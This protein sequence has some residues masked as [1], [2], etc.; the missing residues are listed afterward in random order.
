MKMMPWRS[1]L[2]T[3]PA[4]MAFYLSAACSSGSVPEADGGEALALQTSD[5]ER[6]SAPATPTTPAPPTPTATPAAPATPPPRSLGTPPPAIPARAILIMDEASQ[7]SLYELN[8]DM[9]LAPASLTKIATAM[10]VLE[11]G[12]DLDRQVEVNPDLEQQWLED[13]AVM[14]LNPADKF[15][16]R[17]LLYGLLLVSGNDAARELAVAT[18]GSEAAFVKE[19]NRLAARL[20][21]RN[22][23]F[24]DSHGLGGPDHYSSARDLAVLT[25]YA[26]TNATF[27]Q[28]VATETHTSIGTQ[29]LFLYNH[30]PL[31]NYTPGVD[32]VK[33]G[34][35]EEAGPTFVA[36]VARD[37]RRLYV[38]LLNAPNMALDAIDLIEW[39]FT[40]HRWE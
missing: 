3:L 14:G 29:E 24:I 6:E 28:I 23:H 4:A 36:S 10:V 34:F 7:A 40:N 2:L 39:A 37:G 9:R 31:L 19:M 27:R 33:V 26:M 21:L 22:T 8:A 16:I 20:G 13:S 5:Q 18:S 25:S 1:L 35:T 30:N 15:S 17:E 38:V 32:G 12:I 11:S